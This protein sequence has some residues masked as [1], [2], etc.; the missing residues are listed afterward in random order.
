MTPTE[1]Q[2]YLHLL[3]R[4]TA[5]GP[6]LET[7]AGLQERHMQRVAFENFSVYLGVAPVLSVEALFRK[8]VHERRGGYCFELNTLYGALLEALGFTVKPVLARVLLRDPV[9]TP[10]R[11]HLVNLVELDGAWYVSDVGFGGL[12][13][14]VPLRLDDAGEVDDG[15]GTVRLL[16]Q[17]FDE[18]L[19]QRNTPDGWQ[20]QY[21]FETRRA[22]P[23]DIKLGNYYTHSHPDSHF[24]HHRFIGLFTDTGR[25]GLFGNRFT[26]R[27]GIEV[28]AE[29]TVPDGP[30][31]I[32]FVRERFGLP[33]E[34]PGE[35]LARLMV[36]KAGSGNT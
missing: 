3:D 9:E 17:D 6:T 24:L 16:P 10:P 35:E 20:D 14:R 23:A 13:S 8:V 28:V 22:V 32:A 7:L 2:A 12:A 34:L 33:L 1:V 19:V 18:Y 27:R 26:E 11:T 4:T 30:E 25:M 21:R 36:A 29:R 5:P 31:W 15:D